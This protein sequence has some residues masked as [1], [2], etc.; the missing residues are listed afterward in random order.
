MTHRTPPLDPGS[1]ETVTH[2]KVPR[3]QAQPP[4]SHGRVAE[5]KG[6]KPRGPVFILSN[7]VGLPSFGTAPHRLASTPDQPLEAA[8][9]GRAGN[10]AGEGA[11]EQEPS[12]GPWSAARAGHCVPGA[13]GKE[14][15]P[16][17][18]GCL[19]SNAK[20]GE[21]E[22]VGGKCSRWGGGFPDEPLV[23]RDH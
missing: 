23:G 11:T 5:P 7:P 13:A 20:P 12:L 6:L 9:R 18:E 22:E 15:P 1:Q 3:L 16:G 8:P 10:A 21:A 17:T 19:V 4:M 14:P 2:A